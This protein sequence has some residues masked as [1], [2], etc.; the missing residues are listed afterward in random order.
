MNSDDP[1]TRGVG[2]YRNQTESR[3]QS[4]AIAFSRTPPIGSASP[5]SRR[6]PRLFDAPELRRCSNHAEHI[7]FQQSQ[8]GDPK[9]DG[10]P[11]HMSESESEPERESVKDS[12]ISIGGASDASSWT[13]S[14]IGIGNKG[15]IGNKSDDGSERRRD[16]LS[17]GESEWVDIGWKADGDDKS[18]S[19]RS[20]RDRSGGAKRKARGGKRGRKKSAKVESSED[21]GEGEGGSGTKTPQALLTS[22]RQEGVYVPVRFDEDES[23]ISDDGGLPT[24]LAKAKLPHISKEEPTTLLPQL[25]KLTGQTEDVRLVDR[26]FTN[27]ALRLRQ[28]KLPTLLKLLDIHG[29]FHAFCPTGDGED[30]AAMPPFPTNAEMEER[31]NVERLQF[32]SDLSF[33]NVFNFRLGNEVTLAAYLTLMGKALLAWTGKDEGEY[34]FEWSASNRNSAPDGSQERKP[35]LFLLNRILAAEK[36]A[37]VIAGTDDGE[38]EETDTTRMKNW[39]EPLAFLETT[40][41]QRYKPAQYIS[42]MQEAFQLLCAQRTRRYVF[43]GLFMLDSFHVVIFDRSG[44]RSCTYPYNE[45][46]K[47]TF[48]R[49][50][51]GFVLGGRELLGYDL[52]AS[53]HESGPKAGSVKTL[54]VNNTSYEVI[55]VLYRSETVRGRSVTAF[56]VRC[57]NAVMV[58]KDLFHNFECRHMEPDF[59]L[60]IKKL[61]LP[62]T[63]NL[64]D[65]EMLKLKDGTIDSTSLRRKRDDPAERR[66]HLRM[67]FEGVC[68]TLD[69]FRSHVEFFSALVDIMKAL[70]LLHAHGI[71]HR[72][73]N[74]HNLAL[75][76]T[77]SEAV[78]NAI[79][80]TQLDQQQKHQGGRRN[81]GTQIEETTP[82][83]STHVH[84]VDSRRPGIILDFHYALYIGEK[85]KKPSIFDRTAD[86]AFMSLE[87]M[88]TETAEQGNASAANAYQHDIESLMLVTM[89]TC[90]IYT[91]PGRPLNPNQSIISEWSNPDSSITTLRAKKMAMLMGGARGMFANF[92]PYFKFAV[93]FV[94]RFY[95]VVYPSGEARERMSSS[96]CDIDHDVVIGILEEAV[97]AARQEQARLEELPSSKRKRYDND[98]EYL[99]FATL[100]EY[101][102]RGRESD[103][104]RKF[105]E[106]IK[107]GLLYSEQVRAT[108]RTRID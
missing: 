94:R 91:G 69:M 40:K 103:L 84:G 73:I 106:E 97:E 79:V 43:S 89:S 3:Q 1:G 30:S 11:P 18:K 8:L 99:T 105:H 41:N 32:R 21:E 33:R 51:A 12:G 34:D 100:T 57:G 31:A 78:M 54:M 45:G 98:H 26:L 75:Q 4:T 16:G 96:V 55:G 56:L 37:A 35:D 82:P 62:G 50:I 64:L 108:K 83:T 27:S 59:L 49:F 46:T 6:D 92:T 15:E 20:K 36:R 38:E 24:L 95:E 28:V 70:K 66:V 88:P 5:K 85:D 93:P 9:R 102:L 23:S 72:D 76:D 68:V 81:H 80:R 104:S 48:V 77:P 63:C 29:A 22:G 107:R 17:S 25:A 42:L 58:I 10:P 7:K 13:S 44:T 60:K 101:L 74:I 90:C 53:L 19:M 14:G 61:G 2:P 87:E 71:V 52:T 67:A 65:W 47:E 86:P 39:L